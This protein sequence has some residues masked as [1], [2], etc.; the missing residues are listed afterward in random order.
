[1]VSVFGRDDVHITLKG[2]L[3]GDSATLIGTAKEAPGLQFTAR[4]KRIGD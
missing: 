1:M 4:I 3:S 2:T